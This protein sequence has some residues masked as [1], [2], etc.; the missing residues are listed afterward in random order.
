MCVW[1]NERLRDSGSVT[2]LNC[3]PGGARLRLERQV[4]RLALGRHPAAVPGVEEQEV[5][6]A[7]H[8]Q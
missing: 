8:A 6:R 7:A 2:D 4:L 3:P 5:L 1:H